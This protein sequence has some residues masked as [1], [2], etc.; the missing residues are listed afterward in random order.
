MVM[1]KSKNKPRKTVSAT[2]KHEKVIEKII[3]YSTK[4][5]NGKVIT[6][7]SQE[8]LEELWNSYLVQPQKVTVSFPIILEAD[9][10]HEFST[11]ASALEAL[12]DPIEVSYEELNSDDIETE[13]SYVAIFFLGRTKPPEADELVKK[14]C[15]EEVHFSKKSNRK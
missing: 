10:Y 6:A 2:P 5:P 1:A 9:D 12:V 8:E 4:L 7:N 3:T 13:Y 14:W 11:Y 15:N